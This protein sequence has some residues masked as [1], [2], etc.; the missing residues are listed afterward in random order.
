MV[1]SR[2]PVTLC[3]TTSLMKWPQRMWVFT[4]ACGLWRSKNMFS[5]CEGFGEGSP[6]RSKEEPHRPCFCF[7]GNSHLDVAHSF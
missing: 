3:I 4:P 1:V 7:Q 6:G 5:G 2:D